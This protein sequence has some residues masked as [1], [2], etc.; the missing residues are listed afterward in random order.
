MLGQ[1]IVDKTATIVDSAQDVCI[2][3]T[4]DGCQ[5]PATPAQATHQ[6]ARVNAPITCSQN[7]QN[8]VS[9]LKTLEQQGRQ[10]V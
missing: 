3:V 10:C 1:V 5:F 2:T 7:Q 6:L 4:V 8:I 9:R